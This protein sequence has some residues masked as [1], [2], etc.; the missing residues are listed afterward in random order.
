[1]IRNEFTVEVYEVHARIA[2]EK[3][4][5]GEYNQCQ[6]QLAQLYARGLPGHRMEFVAYRL[7]YFLY[8]K[9]RAG[10]YRFLKEL[11]PEEKRD[12]AVRHALE[13]RR[14][15]AASNYHKLFQLYLNA[16]NMGAYLMDK[17]VERERVAA[18]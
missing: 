4:D 16:V 5:L 1:M 2:L 3:H 12:P 8:T 18:V 6:S 15:L 13:V 11:T 7:L 14:A 9:N 10:V 17:F